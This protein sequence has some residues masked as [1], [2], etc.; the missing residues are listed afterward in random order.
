MK[1][2]A[3]TFNFEHKRKSLIEYMRVKIEESDWHGVSDAA[4]DLRVLE[5]SQ[6]SPKITF[7]EHDSL[8][9]EILDQKERLNNPPAVRLE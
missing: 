2:K 7:T 6:A 9:Q 5:A 4:N 3:R 1:S 8:T